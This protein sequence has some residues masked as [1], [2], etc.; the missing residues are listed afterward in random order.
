MESL[1]Y[2]VA[3]LLLLGMVRE[4]HC[5][6][7]KTQNGDSM[8]LP[9]TRVLSL[10]DEVMSGTDVL[11]AQSLL[12]RDASVSAG[13][14]PP[15]AEYDANTAAA[16]KSFQLAQK[17]NEGTGIFDSST[18]QTLLQLH[19]ADG[20]V[21][22]GFTAKSMGY[23]YK[24]HIPVYLN[25]SVESIG[26]MYDSTNNKL[27]DFRVRAHGYRDDGT[28]QAWP[29][30]GDGDVGVNEFTS[31]GAT[32]TGLIEVDL[33]SPE[34]NPQEYGPWPVNR[35]V[36]GLKGNAEFVLNNFIR[37]GLLLHTGNWT[38]DVQEWN[39]DMDMP[40]SSGC[41]HAHPDD[42]ETIYKTLLGLGVTVHENP[43]TAK[44]YPYKCQGVMVVELIK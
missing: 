33:N 7:P 41:L 44:D 36:R 12:I 19:S 43:F 32:L 37:G 1:L 40:N 20:V 27:L 29:D 2:I 11:I 28:A 13:S 15:N 9:F 25:R 42:I 6:R 34:P 14:L 26:T 17:I 31:N 3:C 10:V 21:D 5:Q 23:L 22:D 24:F 39:P 30:F 16:V 18:A 38:T 4:S 8:P 35:L